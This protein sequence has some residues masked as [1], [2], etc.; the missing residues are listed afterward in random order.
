MAY[1]GAPPGFAPPSLPAG[2]PP[3][4]QG[5]GQFPFQPQFQP[6]SNFNWSSPTIRLGVDGPQAQDSGRDDRR[7][8]SG[9][10]SNAEPLGNRNRLGLGAGREDRG[11]N[12]RGGDRDL[13]RERAAVRESMQAQQPPTREEVARTIFVGGLSDG[14]PGEEQLEDILRCAGKLRRW[15][16]VRDA[17]DRA[18]KFG[19]AEY[20]DVDSLEAANEIF[21]GGVEVPLLKKG[22]ATTGEDGQVKMGQL[23]VVVDEQSRKYISEWKG[24]G[25]EDDDA[26]QFRLDGCREDLRQCITSITNAGAYAANN[27][28][29]NGQNG[30]GDVDMAD[31]MAGS[32]IP[33]LAIPASIPGLEDELSDIPAEM[34]AT[35]AAEIRAFRDRSTRRD[36]ERLRREEE[37]ELA[38]RQRSRLGARASPPPSTVPSGPRGA[39]AVQGAPAGPKGFR[40]AQLP[41]DYQNGVSFVGANGATNGFNRE[42]ED[43]EESDE[44]LERRRRAK[45]DA[46]LD[47]HYKDAER[48]WQNRERQRTAALAREKD[49]EDAEMRSLQREKE[50]I[51][52]RLREWDDKTEEDIGTEEYYF[53]RSS[54][55]RK[56]AVYREREEREDER[57]RFA[58]EHERRREAEAKGLADDF[59]DRTAADLQQHKAPTTGGAAPQGFKISLGSAAA[60]QRAAG[61][62]TIATAATTKR[63]IA[64]TIENLLDDEEDAATMGAN[65]QPH[66]RPLALK[67]IIADTTAYTAQDLSDADRNA[68]RQTL[69]AE[70]PTDTASLF[71]TPLNYT[72]LTDR[73]LEDEIRPFVAKKVVELL[74]VQEDMLVETVIQGLK[75]RKKAEELVRELEGALEEDSELMMRKV[76]RMGVFWGQAGAKGL[77]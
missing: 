41:S 1:Y 75:G 51:G 10:G 64:D 67:P 37:L 49:R 71:A 44:E 36:V 27:A 43:A 38:E 18:C 13:E 42:D 4:V 63:G 45:R 57:D 30:D 40:G 33:S 53:D 21:S 2:S 31:S 62:S 72:Y 11:D 19:F 25:R 3:A 29:T 24:R 61:A 35:V 66:H 20:E 74:G 60:R 59:L 50:A 46:D 16:R 69:A 28:P 15:T 47:R 70:I 54:W 9:R 14:A 34:R 55:L 8:N 39:Q 65:G 6:P 12:R 17:D 7:G 68:A 23:L 22:V 58:E 32:N 56:R 77:H 52:Q 48:K 76:W 73:I 5:H 26:R